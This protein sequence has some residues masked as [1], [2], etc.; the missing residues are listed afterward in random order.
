MWPEVLF[1]QELLISLKLQWKISKYY[2]ALHTFSCQ[3]AL[4]VANKEA[5]HLGMDTSSVCSNLELSFIEA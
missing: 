3:T 5:G 2:F 1:V 4:G